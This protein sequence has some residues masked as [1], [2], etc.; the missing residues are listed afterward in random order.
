MISV[1]HTCL[2]LFVSI[3]TRIYPDRPGGFC[4]LINLRIAKR[5]IYTRAHNMADI[6]AK[7]R[8]PVQTSAVVVLT[9]N[10]RPAIPP[11]SPPSDSPTRTEEPCTSIEDFS[12]DDDNGVA[13]Q[14]KARLANGW[15]VLDAEAAALRNLA[16]LYD[17]DESAQEHFSNAVEAIVTSRR[18]GAKLVVTGVGKS[19]HIGRKLVATFQSLGIA[20]VF[21]HPTEALHGDLGLLAPNDTVLLISFSGKSPELLQL[22][23]H[24]G[25]SLRLVALTSH[26]RSEDC[27][28]LQARPDGLLLPAPIP[29]PEKVV[30]GVSAPT[31]STTVTL[32]LGDALAMAVARELHADIATVFAANHPGGAI[33]AATKQ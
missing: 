24:L 3:S 10:A 11:P 19:G 29:E 2:K 25:P 14:R 27:E 17:T 1:G 32:A 7:Q 22:M 4:W 18:S 8:V 9:D 31:T 20:T 33:G 13:A 16:T 23:P 6:C 5:Q 21:M 12:L 26:R 30:L 28:L 15:R